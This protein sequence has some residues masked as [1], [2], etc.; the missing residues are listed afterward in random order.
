MEK[1]TF[2]Y[3]YSISAHF[4]FVDLVYGFYFE[5]KESA[6]EVR[7]ILFECSDIVGL[8]SESYC[9][10]VTFPNKIAIAEDELDMFPIYKS[11][12]DFINNNQAFKRFYGEVYN[13]KGLSI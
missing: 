8:G 12:D 7:N 2:C 13:Q 6:M 4:S 1:K 3:V 10:V 5:D 9:A 11:S